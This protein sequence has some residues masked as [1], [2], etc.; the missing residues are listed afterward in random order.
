MGQRRGCVFSL[1][2]RRPTESPL[3][4]THERAVDFEPGRIAEGFEM[5][6]GII[7][8]HEDRIPDRREAVNHIFE[9]YGNKE[10]RRV[11]CGGGAK[12]FA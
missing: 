2:C 3:P 5:G 8:F 9:Y 6:G 12:Q 11:T 4:G 7:E 10:L 1:S